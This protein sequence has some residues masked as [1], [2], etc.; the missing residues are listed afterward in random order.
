M[1]FSFA[2]CTERLPL[3]HFFP[4]LSK[5]FQLDVFLVRRYETVALQARE[6]AAHRLQREPEVAA[7]VLARHAQAEVRRGI[8]EAL[9]AARKAQEKRRDAL[10][11]V[12]RPHE[13]QQ[14][15]V[16]RDVAAQDAQQLR[17]ELGDARSELGEARK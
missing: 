12:H 14:A 5:V 15:V 16:A 9:V 4:Q 17:L 11:G 10:F 8:A 7:D 1:L 2:A 13:Q 3:T 6:D